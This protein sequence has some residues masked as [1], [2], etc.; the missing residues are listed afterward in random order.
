MKL[1]QA[2]AK[3]FR[4]DIEA[5]GPQPCTCAEYWACDSCEVDA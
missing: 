4:H 1:T 5:P 2:L 3:I